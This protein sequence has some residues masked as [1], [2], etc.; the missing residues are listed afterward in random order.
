MKL[1][2][3]Y[4][5]LV[6]ATPYKIPPQYALYNAALYCLEKYT[7]SEF[8]M[9][10]NKVTGFMSYAIWP[11][12]PQRLVDIAMF[13]CDVNRSN[14]VL[15]HDMLNLVKELQREYASVEWDAAEKNPANRIYQRLVQKENGRF[16][17]N[18]D[19]PGLIHYR[20]PGTMPLPENMHYSR[21]YSLLD[22]YTRRRRDIDMPDHSSIKVKADESVEDDDWLQLPKGFI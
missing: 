14:N 7:A 18:P 16:G 9:I 8:S 15:L 1:P 10:G 21:D 19:Q 12:F 13:S 17:D 6:A 4:V 20:L 5:Y 22:K 11:F 3:R 2:P